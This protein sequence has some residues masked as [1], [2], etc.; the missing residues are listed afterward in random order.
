[1]QLYIILP[2]GDSFVFLDKEMIEEYI[3]GLSLNVNCTYAVRV[4]KNAHFLCL[5]YVFVKQMTE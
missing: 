5:C 3:L 4:G 1:M 2:T